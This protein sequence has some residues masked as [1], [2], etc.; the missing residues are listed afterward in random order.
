MRPVCRL[1]V[2]IAL[3]ALAGCDGG[4]GESG[5]QEEPRLPV[6]LNAVMVSLIN[7][8]ADPIWVATWNAPANDAE[9]R[10]L[11][12]LAYQIQI[13]GSLIQIPGS[14]PR[15]EEWTSDPRWIALAQQ[16]SENGRQAVE[17]VRSR[18]RAEMDRVGNELVNTCEACHVEFKP[19]L[20]TMD[21]FGELPQLPPASL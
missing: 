12:R 13:G 19:D 7:A 15:D 6:S 4:E 8:A 11:E 9:W 1:L 17:A 14:G 18:D 2:A 3:I 20:P 10:Q 5:P 16:L 21:M